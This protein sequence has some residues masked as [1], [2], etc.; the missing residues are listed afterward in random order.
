M[1]NELLKIISNKKL[2]LIII[3]AFSMLAAFMDVL[4]AGLLIPLITALSGV[5]PESGIIY[6]ISN[7]FSEYGTV[8][9][10]KIISVLLLI[11]V[12]CKGLG[13]YMS[14]VT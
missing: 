14:D 8:D 4:M 9:L 7:Y 6:T 12:V 2:W 13:I 11:V 1:K 3:I 10:L 5:E